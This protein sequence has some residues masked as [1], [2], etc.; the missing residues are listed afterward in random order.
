MSKTFCLP[1]FNTYGEVSIKVDADR[2]YIGLMDY[3]EEYMWVKISP[4]LFYN[5]LEEL[6]LPSYSEELIDDKKL[7]EDQNKS[8]N[9]LEKEI[10]KLTK[11]INS[12]QELLEKNA[13]SI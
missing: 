4:K 1:I 7:F 2:H 12:I 8:N 9:Y 5:L 10:R 3:D 13:S 6:C 11:E